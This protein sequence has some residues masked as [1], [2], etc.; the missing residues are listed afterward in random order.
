AQAHRADPSLIE[1]LE[2]LV[3]ELSDD[4]IEIPGPN[5]ASDRLLGQIHR[6]VGGAADSDPHDPGRARLSAGADDRFQDE[7]LDPLHT[8]GGDAH[9]QEAHVLRARTLRYAL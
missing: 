4:R 2:K 8:V 9:L 7:L 3:L 5:R 1:Q 6:V